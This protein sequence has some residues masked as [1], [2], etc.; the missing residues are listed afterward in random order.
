MKN[1]AI[2]LFVAIAFFSCDDS[3]D[4]SN[5]AAIATI[6]VDGE[7]VN[8]TKSTIINTQNQDDTLYRMIFALHT[9]GISYSAESGFRGQGNLMY[10]HFTSP[11]GT[12][13]ADGT[14]TYDGG[15]F[16]N[17]HFRGGLLAV[18]IN[19]QAGQIGSSDKLYVFLGGEASFI[20][21]DVE[22]DFPPNMKAEPYTDFENGITDPDKAITISGNF[23]V[24]PAFMVALEEEE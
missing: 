15:N 8:F 23:R 20:R 4:E 12:G 3:D 22:Y 19:A 13:L 9:D 11:V 10:S 18:N 2:F 6:E 17:F 24:T 21:N 5:S 1:F 16:S 14:Y 7:Q